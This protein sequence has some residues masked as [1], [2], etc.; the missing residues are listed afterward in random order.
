MGSSDRTLFLSKTF[1]GENA[2]NFSLLQGEGHNLQIH[3]L[4]FGS[5]YTFRLNLLQCAYFIDSKLN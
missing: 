4:L 5:K 3:M 1:V 2:I